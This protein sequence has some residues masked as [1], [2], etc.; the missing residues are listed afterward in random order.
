MAGVPRQIRQGRL[1]VPVISAGEIPRIQ[2]SSGSARALEAFSRDMFSLADGFQDQLDQ[3]AEAEATTQGALAGASGD[4]E[5]QDYGTIRGR[6]FNK[7]AI[8]TF[9]TTMET[10]SILKVQEL[11]ARFANDPAG[12]QQALDDYAGGVGREVE[13]VYAPAGAAFRQRLALRSAPAV[14]AAKDNRYQLTR[15]QADAALI[16]NEVALKAEIS[17]LS[18]D[19]FSDNPARSDAAARAVGA[20]QGEYLRIFDAVDPTTGRP[21]YNPEERAKARAAFYEDVMETAAIGWFDQQDDKAGAYIK[22]TEGDFTINLETPGGVGKFPGDATAFLADRLQDQ[23]GVEHIEGMQPEMR[24]RLALMISEAPPQVQ[25]GLD[26]LSGKRS[27][28]RQRQ[29]WNASDKTGRMVA[30]PGHSRH[31]HGDA[32]DLGWNGGK[33]SE[34]PAAV[35]EWVHAN[36]GKYGLRFP[37][38]YEPWHIETFEARGHKLPGAVKQAVDVRKALPA[39]VMGRIESEMRA[40]I[41]FRNSLADREQAAAEKQLK[42]EQDAADFEYMN[43]VFATGN[44]PVTGNPVKPLTREEVTAAVR[45]GFLSPDAGKAIVRAMAVDKPERSDPDTYRDALRRLYQGENIRNFVLDN[46]DKFSG[47]DA[48]ELLGKNETLREQGAGTLSKEEQFHFNNLQ[49][50]LTPDSLMAKIDDGA[51]DR[52]YLAL[53]EYRRRIIGG[54]VPRDVAFDIRERARRDMESVTGTKLDTLVRPRFFAPGAQPGRIDVKA[55]AQNLVKAY[56]AKQ[57]SEDEYARQQRV[58]QEWAQVQEALDRM[59]GATKK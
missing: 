13:K 32:A 52:K 8:E 21:L 11:Q 27:S 7:A 35:R 24:D 25:A 22:F 5:Q 10:N 23:H 39:D 9:V 6:A 36:A 50:L 54:E 33:F 12:L 29:L 58:I 45:S 14:E 28:A 53:D 43:R 18:A 48:S 41:S 30:R 37:M 26:I 19:L 17:S 20:L 49:D 2:F 15:Q 40:R 1:A 55:T 59:Q 34:A 3:Q 42:R 44:D 31:E 56:K 38:S 51:E 4:F 57:I 16:Q 47:S 46:A